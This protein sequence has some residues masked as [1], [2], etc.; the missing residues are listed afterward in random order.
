VHGTVTY[1]PWQRNATRRAYTPLARARDE[2]GG[3]L[4]A[5]WLRRDARRVQPSRRGGAPRRGGALLGTVRRRAPR[6]AGCAEQKILLGGGETIFMSPTS[7]PVCFVWSI[8][9]DKYSRGAHECDFAALGQESARPGPRRRTPTSCATS[10]TRATS[11]PARPGSRLVMGGRRAGFLCLP[12][13][14]S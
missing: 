9:N 8:A 13:K 10:T 11:R 5:R 4:G 12:A 6:A 7:Y 1:H 3:G 2:A 14:K